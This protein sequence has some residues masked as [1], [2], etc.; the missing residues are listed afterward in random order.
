MAVHNRDVAEILN[1]IADLLE[2][3]DANPFRV[4]SYRNAARTIADLSGNAADMVE[5]G[6]DLSDLPG[7]GKDLAGKIQEI[8]RTGALGQLEELRRRTTPQLRE[9]T[10]ISSLGPKRV[11]KLHEELGVESLEELERA[12]REQK[13]RGVAGFGAKTESNILRDLERRKERGG[14]RRFLWVEI[15]EYAEPL[16][17]HLRKGKGVGR[18]AAAGSYRRRKETVGD[19]DI[20]ATCEDSGPVMERFVSYEEVERVLSRGKTRSSVVLRSGIQVDLRVVGEESYGAALHYFTG[21]KA[22]NVATRRIAVAKGLK[23]N[24]YGVFRGTHGKDAGGKSSGGKEDSE[25]RRVAGKTEEEVYEQVGLPYIEPELREDRG[26]IE[27]AREGRL[28]ELVQLDDVRGDLQLHTK[29]TDG[30]MT[31][32]EMADAAQKLGYEYMAVTDHSK[33][34]TMAQGLDER[35]LAEQIEEIEG[36]NEELG[37]GF[38]I[39]KSC[40]VDILKDGSL[41]LPD[42]ILKELDLVIGSV[43]YNTNLAGEKQ[44]ERVLRAMDNPYFSILAHPTGRILGSREPYDLDLE[45]IMKAALDRGCYLEINADPARLDLDDVHAKMAREM[46]LKVPISTD[47]HT[48]T[49]LGHMRLGVAQARRGW[50]SKRD[51]LNTLP[52]KEL[53]KLLRR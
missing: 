49:S 14:E 53:A 27:A 46:G 23:I 40:E 24:E 3:E 36:I 21:S 8:V 16:L 22:H 51:V 15:E 17:E 6:E 28:P 37:G 1:E 2:I 41:D 34:V 26:E 35:R 45:R 9:L 39:L 5:R 50:L 19:L 25:R 11:Q 32:R 12:A 7:I 18:L 48:A 29:A 38:R 13:L 10:Q 30:K 47:A 20:L 31:I 33:R 52:W 42:S 4:R 44:T 43:H